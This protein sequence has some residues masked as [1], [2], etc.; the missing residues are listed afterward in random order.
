MAT[1]RKN[2]G[3]AETSYWRGYE[4]RMVLV[5][6]LAISFLAF[7]R[8]AIGYLGPYLVAE[9]GLNNAQLG[10]VYS[11]QA[12]AVAL[13][14]LIMGRVSDRSGRRVRLLAPLLVLSALCAGSTLLVHGYA[15]LLV[16][17]LASGAALGGISPITQSIV[18]AQSAPARLGRNI[19]IQTL[20]MFLVSQMAGPLILPRVAE[21]WGW[22]A[23]FV[24][25]AVPFL[26][27]AAAVVMLLRETPTDAGTQHIMSD[28]NENASLSPEA[29]RTVWLCL[30]ISA[31]FM[32]W[33][34]IHSTFLSVYLVQRRGLTPT[35][36]GAILGMLGVA[37]GLGGLVLPMMSDRFGRRPVLMTGMLLSALVPLSTLLWHGPVWGLQI[38]LS[39]GWMA[40]GALPIYAVMIPGEA[41]PRARVAGVV[42]LVI[43]IGEIVGGMAGPLLAGWLADVF[44]ISAP[45]WLAFAAV[46]L[47]FGLTMALP[48]GGR[49]TAG[50]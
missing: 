27:L 28:K 37:G 46:T 33:L 19:G 14:G 18:T 47:C 21:H 17:R 8:L 25:S 15:M 1:D 4:G 42:A 30:G 10:A 35:E 34:V 31:C 44:D 50:R 9:L 11:V 41:V 36:A 7:D 22:Q 26:L 40:V 48:A 2:I 45:F 12:M 5:T 3:L 38:C 24:V 16:V 6:S 20:L 43:G 23:G 49:G 32:V 39:I 29:R 13:T